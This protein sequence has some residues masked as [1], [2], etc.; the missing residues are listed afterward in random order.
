MDDE[1]NPDY[2][3]KLKCC[4][5]YVIES[6]LIYFKKNIVNNDPYSF[7]KKIQYIFPNIIKLEKKLL[8]FSKELF[9]I[10]LIDKI[11]NYYDKK[12]NKTITFFL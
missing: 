11:I 2:S 1:R 4:F 8:L 9:D 5:Y 7:Y 12:N 10:E 3:K 6:L